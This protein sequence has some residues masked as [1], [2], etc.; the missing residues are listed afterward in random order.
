MGEHLV[1][2]RVRTCDVTKGW[3][4]GMQ[5]RVLLATVPDTMWRVATT[6]QL[7]DTGVDDARDDQES[8]RHKN[9]DNFVPMA[10]K[11]SSRSGVERSKLEVIRRVDAAEEAVERGKTD[12]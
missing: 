1:A 12:G 5:E 7:L 6:K 10:K 8:K 2:R 9:S 4:S 3:H 11:P